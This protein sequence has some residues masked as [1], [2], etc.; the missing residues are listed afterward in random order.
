MT[1]VGCDV[2]SRCSDRLENFSFLTLSG[3]PDG[4]FPEKGT[5]IRQCKFLKF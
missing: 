3:R 5:Q 2:S 1:G 4:W